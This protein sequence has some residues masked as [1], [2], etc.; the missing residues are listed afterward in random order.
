MTPQLLITSSA[1][2]PRQ[3]LTPSSRWPQVWRRGHVL[4]CLATMGCTL[5]VL[6]HTLAAILRASVAA[7]QAAQWGGVALLLY[8]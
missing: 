6:A 1:S 8:S 5:S 3:A 2:W 7:F 4:P